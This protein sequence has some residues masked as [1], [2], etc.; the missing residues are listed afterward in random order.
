M[1]LQQIAFQYSV[2]HIFE[3]ACDKGPT[4]AF[5]LKTKFNSDYTD[6][7]TAD[8]ES[9]A[10]GRLDKR[11]IQ[12]QLRREE[13][14]IETIER[15]TFKNALLICGAVHTLGVVARLHAAKYS[16][17]FCTHALPKNLPTSPGECKKILEVLCE[18]AL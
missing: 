14:W 5:K 13:L 10:L 9:I 3:E 4:T 6:L 7:D 18:L 2:D 11:T 15:T 12:Q 1:S 17:D 8:P 16:V